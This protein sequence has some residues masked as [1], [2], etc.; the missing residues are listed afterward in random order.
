[1]IGEI[2]RRGELLTKPI[3]KELVYPDEGRHARP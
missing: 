3:M 2:N 1:M